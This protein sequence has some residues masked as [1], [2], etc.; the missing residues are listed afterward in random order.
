[1]YY[2]I[3]EIL[4]FLF[5]IYSWFFQGVKLKCTQYVGQCQCQYV[6]QCLLTNPVLHWAVHPLLVEDDVEDEQNDEDGIVAASNQQWTR[7]ENVD[8]FKNF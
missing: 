7:K 8:M 4:V 1:M 2:E 3:L 5:L 6:G